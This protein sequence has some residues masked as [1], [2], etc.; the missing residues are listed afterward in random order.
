MFKMTSNSNGTLALSRIQAGCRAKAA[1]NSKPGRA[2]AARDRQGN[3]ERQRSPFPPAACS[4]G[5]LLGLGNHWCG[6]PEPV[7]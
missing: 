4:P 1:A 3:G 6:L 7:R 5:H 2:P